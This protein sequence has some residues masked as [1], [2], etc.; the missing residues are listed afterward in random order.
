MFVKILFCLARS[1]FSRFSPMVFDLRGWLSVDRLSELAMELK[2]EL[3]SE[4]ELELFE[5]E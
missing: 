2:S 3:E 4:L 5:S 1:L